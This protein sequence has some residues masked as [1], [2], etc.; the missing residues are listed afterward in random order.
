MAE[1]AGGM[2]VCV[3][4]CEEAGDREYTCCQTFC[5]CQYFIYPYLHAF[6]EGSFFP[7]GSE[8]GEEASVR[9]TKPSSSL[10]INITSSTFSM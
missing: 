10:P 5:H 1:I 8:W 9:V 3:P 4:I 2:L 7:N 6:S